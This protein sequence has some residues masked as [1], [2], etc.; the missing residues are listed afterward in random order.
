M[1]NQEKGNQNI[2]VQNQAD[3]K[4][5]ILNI[6][7]KSL[8]FYPDIEKLQSYFQKDSQFYRILENF[9]S[10][11]PDIFSC[12][13]FFKDFPENTYLNDIFNCLLSSD[14]FSNVEDLIK[15]VLELTRLAIGTKF[16]KEEVYVSLI[17]LLYL[18]LQE[19]VYGSSFFFIKE[20]EKT[21]FK[22]DLDNFNNSFFKK[23]EEKFTPLCDEMYNYLSVDGESPYMNMKLLVFYIICYELL[24]QNYFDDFSTVN[25]WR[26][27]IIFIHSRMLREP[28]ESLKIKLFNA[29]NTFDKLVIEDEISKG[30]LC[31]EKSYYHLKFYEYK[32]CENEIELARQ[33]FKL[34]LNLTGRL[35]RKTKFQEFDTA[36][37]YLE[38]ESSTL[39]NR[40][41]E[42]DT[43]NAP[44]TIQLDENN[45]LL[46]S[47]NYTDEN[48]EKLKNTKLSLFDQM[49][50]VSYVNYL[51]FSLPDEDLLR[52]TIITY[53]N[54][55]LESYFDW[56]VS[57]KLLLQKSLA[58]D[59]KTKTVER[60][61]TQIQSL[62]DGYNDRSIPPYQRLRYIFATDFPFIWNMKKHYAQMYMNFGAVLTAFDIFEELKMWEECIQCLYVAGKTEK[63][64][65]FAQDILKKKE[66]PGVYCVLGELQLKEE[67]FFKALNVS[68][69]KYTRAYRCLGKFYF[70]V[71]NDLESS[72]K[73]YDL[74]LAINPL[75]PGI[76][77]TVGCIHLRM[78]N[79]TKAVS[80][81][82][83]ALALDDTNAETWANL[84]LAFHETGKLKESLKCLDEGLKRQRSNW[85]I[86]ENLMY[87]SIDAKNI[88]KLIFAMNH[89]FILDKLDRIK[90]EAYYNL[91]SLFLK[92]DDEGVKSRLDYYKNK[93]NEIF[94]NFANKDGLNAEVWSLYALFVESSELNEKSSEEQKQKIYKFVIELRLKQAR[95]LMIEDV[96]EKDEKIIEKLKKV[97]ESIE[98]DLKRISSQE[99]VI[100][101]GA[102]VGNVNSKIE[103]FYK[104]KNFL[105]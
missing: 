41:Q 65:S 27:R 36:V 77:F 23:L 70:S 51:K 93:I 87:I 104:L 84:A 31:L 60:A 48:R 79:W 34:E 33:A 99:K 49:Y 21:D 40:L 58:E 4:T 18:F 43:N 72:L 97:I 102:F 81:F 1:E 29:R 85:K 66:D 15:R 56:T 55:G 69:N 10:M 25:L 73:Y 54:K 32:K 75:F 52:D 74:A 59:K 44:Q 19:S 20:T 57:S 86:C 101:V 13:N 28:A 98:S 96:W 24:N 16:N 53:V 89:L 68:K 71:K 80:A 47:P 7:D 11:T 62:C 37:L 12:F 103:K 91:V 94:E 63:A 26:A 90:P 88:N 82:S 8:L 42:D 39:V 105:P 14:K 5:E 67:Y 3:N 92:S 9:K 2:K 50:F 78:K 95:N 100:E 17:I 64:L 83:K 76:W 35:G 6:I 30:I 22:K 45:P 46:E 61:L 38:A